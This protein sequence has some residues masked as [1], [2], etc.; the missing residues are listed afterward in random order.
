MA[1]YEKRDIASNEG[2]DLIFLQ[3]PA[4]LGFKKTRVPNRHTSLL[5]FIW[6][7]FEYTH[8]YWAPIVSGKGT[9]WL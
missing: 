6:K 8:D 9:N 7:Y 4:K 3:V 5:F 2:R 1:G